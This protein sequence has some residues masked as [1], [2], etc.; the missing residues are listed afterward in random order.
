MAFATAAIDSGDD[1]DKKVFPRVTWLSQQMTWQTQERCVDNNDNDDGGNS[2]GDG[3][4]DEKTNLVA[5]SHNQNNSKVTRANSSNPALSSLISLRSTTNAAAASKN[6]HP[7]PI[8]G[9]RHYPRWRRS[10]QE[11]NPHSLGKEPS[12]PFGFKQISLRLEY[13]HMDGLEGLPKELYYVQ[14]RRA[15]GP[16]CIT[17]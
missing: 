9:N 17:L 3:D 13:L 2:N 14:A 15:S 7:H 11:H 8:W 10:V 6:D 5:I 1:D 12:L 16:L 4:D